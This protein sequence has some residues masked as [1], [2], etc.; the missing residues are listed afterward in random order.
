M[1]TSPE[2]PVAMPMVWGMCCHQR[3]IWS[4]SVLARVSHRLMT[5]GFLAPGVMGNTCQPRA[6]RCRAHVRRLGAVVS[7]AGISSS[8][9]GQHY[10]V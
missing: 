9:C 1:T 7:A 3:V 8:E 4:G 5:G 6:A 2:G 10:S